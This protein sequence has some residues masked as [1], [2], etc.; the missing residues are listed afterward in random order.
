MKKVLVL[1]GGIAGVEAA[2]FLQKEGLA[3][4]LVSERNYFF[5]NPTSIWV[6]TGGIAFEK[7]CIGL[8]ALQEVHGFALVI[9]RVAEIRSRALEAVLASGVVL[10]GYDYMVVAVGASK[11][12]HPGIEHTLS[13]CGAPEESL[14]LRE[15]IDALVAKG[16]GRIAMGFGG[17]P[18]DMSAVRGGPGFELMF[19]VAHMLRKK[20]LRERFELTMFAPMEEP[21]K[22]MGPQALK[23]MGLFFRKLGIKHRFGTKIAGFDAAGVLFE[24]GSRLDADLTMFIPAG[25]GHDVVKASDLPTNEAGFVTIDDTCRVVY[26]DGDGPENVYAIGDVAALEGPQWRAKQGHIAEVMARNTAFNIARQSRG[27]A[28]RKGYQEHLNILCIMDSGDG[29]A[30]VYRDDKRA[31]MIPLPIVGHWIKRLWGLYFRWSKLGKIFRLPG[32]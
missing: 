4:T 1:G 3:V 30:F 5:I 22:R 23:M 21:G 26:P 28:M 12:K 16:G 11:M 6:P 10:K 7:V 32:M 24:D 31:M 15:R 9:D 19:N 18:K 13:I 2:I 29:A 14:K 25:N 27:E 17:N 20:G 8:E